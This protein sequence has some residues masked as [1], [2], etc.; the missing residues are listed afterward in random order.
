MQKILLF[1]LTAMAV[2]L[3]AELVLAEHNATDYTI[4]YSTESLSD[5]TVAEE[6]AQYLKQITGAAFPI[7]ASGQ[8][9]PSEPGNCIYIGWQ[10]PGDATPLAPSERRVKSVGGDIYLYGTN[11]EG[12]EFAVYDFL[13]HFL[14]CRFY[15]IRGVER[16]PENPRP[17][18]TILDNSVAPCFAFTQLYSGTW[19]F[20]PEPFALFSR[21]SRIFILNPGYTEIGPN[22]YH[23]PGRLIPPGEKYQKH[24]GIW[25]PYRISAG[26]GYFEEHPEYFA[27]N[28]QGERVF[29]RQLCYSNQ[30]LRQLFTAKLE[31][32]VREE[33]HGGPA[34]QWCDLN[35]NN[36]FEG[37]TI[38][39]C[40]E[41]MK[42]V[43]KYHSPAGPYW[44]Y[45]FEVCRYYQEKYPEITLITTAYLSTERPPEGVGEM[46]QNLLVK[47]CPLNKNY[48]KP[49]DHPTNARIITRLQQWNALKARLSVQLYPSVYPRFTSILPLVANLRQLAQNLRV[50]HQYG[51]T[52]LE[53]EQGHPWNNVNA[54]NEVRQYMLSKLFNDITLDADEVIADA[55]HEI[56]GAA[57]PMMIRY[58]Q[59][60]EELEANETVGLTWHGCGFGA[61]SYLTAENLLRWCH[62]FDVME[63][64]VANDPLRLNAV[65]DARV[66][67]D[68][69]ILSVHFRLPD[70]PEFNPELLAE[71]VRRE[72]ARSFEGRPHGLGATGWQ[73]RRE[74]LL[75]QRVVN[76]VDYFAALAVEPRPIPPG[77]VPS[78]IG[79]VHR[80]LPT[81]LLGGQTSNVHHLLPDAEAP[82]GVALQANRKNL[83]RLRVTVVS[84]YAPSG[85]QYYA[86]LNDQREI[87]RS[88]LE[89]HPGQYHTYYVGSTRLWPQCYLSAHFLDLAGIIPI[90]QFFRPETPEAEYDLHLALKLD[91]NGEL[92]IGELILVQRNEA[93]RPQKFFPA[94]PAG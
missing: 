5:S 8:N 51:V 92:W 73:K 84:F 31:Q 34:F 55:M 36:G 50:C 20:A 26:E 39:C 80:T 78:D 2:A 7:R 45:L 6:L 9:P 62:D 16:I 17:S 86:P 10:A 57:A 91:D 49:Y 79:E 32:I 44:D 48:M 43:E 52:Y 71:R 21:K 53:A 63:A 64:L 22:Y 4:I 89:G 37:K 69:N 76:G 35:D 28:P 11:R 59:E 88:E 54:F 85:E 68:E 1:L 70:L 18:W 41:C 77:S 74:Y 24:T 83:E 30:E 58:W 25:T 93:P 19:A 65:R 94:A 14:G 66:N 12:H 72:I 15:T 42:L 56:Y 87:P 40:P 90:G 29:N 46:P 33:Y 3:R 82:F 60:L 23:V 38:C 13:E 81:R 27:L 61:F 75:D 67:L 47:F